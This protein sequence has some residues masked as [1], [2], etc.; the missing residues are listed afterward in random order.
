MLGHASLNHIYR[1]VWNPSLGVM[2]AVSEICGSHAHSGSGSGAVA[3]A[4]S[5]QFLG[6]HPLAMAAALACGALPLSVNA[7]PTGGVAIVGTAQ[8]SAVGNQLTVTTQNGA[9][10]GHSAINW[11][12][13]S[14]PKG[15]TTYFAQPNAT[16][17]VINRVLTQTPSQIFGILGSNGHVV[18]VNQSGITVGAGAVVDTAGFTASALRMTDADALAGRLRFGDGTAVDG[19]GAVSV[20]GHILARSGDVVILGSAIDTGKDALIQSPGGSTLLAAGRQIELTGRGLEGISLQVQAPSDQAVNLGTLQGDAVGIFAGTLKHSGLVQA[21]T[22]TL[23]GGKVV[24]RAIQRA[25]VDGSISTQGAGGG[26][27]KVLADMENGTVHVSGALDASAPVSGNGG[28]IE[29]S[30]ANVALPVAP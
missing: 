15:N 5:W 16:S 26:Q 25:D 6:L 13:F 29:T 24:L 1:T 21:T 7:N 12:T 14:I 9:G 30:A 22:A 11:Q 10:Q 18:L 19:E 4:A 17:T 28:F 23:E 8:M 27:I 2:V 20:L 3:R